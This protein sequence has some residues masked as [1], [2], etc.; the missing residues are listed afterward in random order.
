[1]VKNGRY[2]AGT[3]KGNEKDVNEFYTLE[4]KLDYPQPQKVKLEHGGS[5]HEQGYDDREDESLAMRHGKIASKH[6]V[7]SHHRREHSRRDDARFE[8]RKK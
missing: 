7:G 8:T 6:F 2:I 3:P 1:M 5:T 4:D